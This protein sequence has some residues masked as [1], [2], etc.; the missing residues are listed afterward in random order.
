MQNAKLKMKNGRRNRELRMASTML[1]PG[2]LR[3]PSSLLFAL[4]AFLFALYASAEAQQTST[5]YRLGFLSPYSASEPWSMVALDALRQGLRDFGYV[6]GKNVRIEYR[7]GEGN[8][9][10]LLSLAQELVRLNVRI[11]VVANDLT[12]RAAKKATSTIPVVM[13][14]SGNPIGTGMISSL[15][16]PGSNVTGL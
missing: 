13:A 4:T 11:L 7:Y 15:A 10:Q 2:L 12:A 9:E 5:V 16:R 1:S 3:A 14:S 8:L 6:E